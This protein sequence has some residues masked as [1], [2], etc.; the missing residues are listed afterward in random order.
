MSKLETNQVDPA[1]GT[2]LTLGTS[3]DTITIPSGVTIANSGTATGFG[4]ANTPAFEAKITTEQNP[5]GATNVKINFDNE[6][7]DT[8]SAYSTTDKRF[9]VPSGQAGKYFIYS[10]TNMGSSANSGFQTGDLKIYKNGSDQN[11]RGHFNTNNDG[12][13]RYYQFSI[14]NIFDL[15][16]GD[17]IEM[18]CYVNQTATVEVR[19]AESRFGGFKII[20]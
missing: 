17:Y 20:E 13:G 14:F 15:S 9:T 1:T 2:T 11:A 18:Y 8:A 10:S 5:T 3:G 16:V 7:F 19:T 6:I 12:N 4:G